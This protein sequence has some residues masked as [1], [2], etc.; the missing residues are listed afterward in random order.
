MAATSTA[1]EISPLAGK[2]APASILVDVA[3]L[4]DAYYKRRPDP[5]E[6]GQRVVFGTSGHRGSSLQTAFNEDHILAITQAICLHRKQGGI[7]GPLFIGFDTH[8]LSKPAFMTALG[9]LAAN[10]VDVMVDARDGYTP[11]PV[12]SHAVLGYNR[13]RRRGLADGIVITPSHN[14]PQY[15]GFKYDPPHGGPADTQVTR[16]IEDQ[17][18]SF[19]ADGLRGVSRVPFDRASSASTTHRHEYLDAYV[20]DLVSVV[21]LEAI[22]ASRVRIGVDPLGGASVA[23]WAAIGERYGLDLEVVNR[24]VDPTF[25]FMTVDW[26]GQIRMDPSSPY[27][28]AGMVALKERFD[29]AFA[30]DADADRHGI[31]SHTQGLLDPNHYL[32]VAIAYLFANRPQWPASAAVGKTLVSSSLIDRVAS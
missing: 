16:W 17:A 23:Y 27:A 32:T 19:L 24:A 7:D 31:V 22:R 4:V 14:P 11:T 29:V 13:G 15:G 30:N 8:A 9:V 6:P 3:G 2:P 26:D 1:T 10:G 25:R 5:S 28:M 21:D 18:N 12:V 20:S